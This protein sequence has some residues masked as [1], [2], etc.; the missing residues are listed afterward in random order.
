M[1]T[2]WAVLVAAFLASAVEFV[3]AITIVFVVGITNNWRS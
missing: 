1:G 3:E 2:Q